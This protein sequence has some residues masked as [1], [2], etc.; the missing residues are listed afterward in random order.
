MGSCRPF[1]APSFGTRKLAGLKAAARYK[2][3]TEI[4]KTCHPE[5]WRYKSQ[6]RKIKAKSKFKGAGRRPA[7]QKSDSKSPARRRRYDRLRNRAPAVR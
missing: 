3:K 1:F 4:K 5:G 7:V 6:R 2:C